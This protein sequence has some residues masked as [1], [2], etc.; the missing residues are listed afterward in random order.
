MLPSWYKGRIFVGT[1]RDD[2]DAITYVQRVLRCHETGKLDEE[3]ACALRGLQLLFSL[4]PTG[5][6]DDATA[7]CI[8]NIWP[9]GA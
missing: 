2:S 7:Q 6:I 8:A 3:L 1:T 9:E 4:R 5:I